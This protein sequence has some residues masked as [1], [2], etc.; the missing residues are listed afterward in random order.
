MFLTFLK[1]TL[2]EA[3]KLTFDSEYVNEDFRTVRI[4]ID[5]P[6]EQAGYPGIWVDFEPEG[7]LET[8]GIDHHEYATVSEE[9]ETTRRVG[10]WRFQGFATFTIV[11]MSSLERDRL[12]DEVVRVMAFGKEQ[13]QT[14]QFRSY[15]E[16]NEFVAMN[17]D[18][19]QIGV[20]GVSAVPGTPW[21]TE[22]VIYEITVSMEC[23]GEFVS[24]GI[25]ATLVP[26]SAVVMYPY[27]DDSVEIPA[28]GLV[29]SGDLD[30]QPA[31]AVG[32]DEGWR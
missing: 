25:G 28:A 22:E 30:E 27:E 15:I 10:R 9:E 4:S 32:D 24:D 17:I 8:V 14:N 1:T 13:E 20:S 19:D 29:P 3:M 7:Q 12:F 5:Y 18:F 16:D 11:A 6:V 31:L 21:G 2:V 23:V 26:L